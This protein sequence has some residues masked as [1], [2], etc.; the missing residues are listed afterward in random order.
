LGLVSACQSPR[1]GVATQEVDTGYEESLDARDATGLAQAGGA[2]GSP[3][4]SIYFEFDAS[5]LSADAQGAL[6]HNAQLLR[7]NPDW[8]IRIEGNCDERGSDEYNLALGKRRAE[9]ART[10]L[11]DLGIE[12]SR[13]ETISYGEEAPIVLGSSEDAWAQNRR[14]DFVVR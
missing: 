3:L 1:R 4:R 2:R 7:D 5:S 11:V 13:L 6:R 14:D 9:V 8:R 10:Y 12:G